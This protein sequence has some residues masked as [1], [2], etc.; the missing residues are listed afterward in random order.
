MSDGPERGSWRAPG[1]VPG[2]GALLGAAL[3]AGV[4]AAVAPLGDPDLPEHLAVGEWILRHGAVPWLEPF[5]WTRAG[6]P[7]YAYSWAAQVTYYGVLKLLGPV[8]LHLL[9]ALIGVGAVLAAALW[10]RRRG[11][12]AGTA[13]V[14]GALNFA[15]LGAVANQLRPEQLLFLLLPLAWALADAV[16]GDAAAAGGASQQATTAAPA[17]VAAWRRRGA[18]LLLGH[19]AVGCAAANV[20]LFFALTAAPLALRLLA[21]PSGRRHFLLPGLALVMGWLLS[22]Y[23][24]ALGDVLAL[25]F[26]P[27]VLLRRPPA[28]GEME[29]GFEA[30]FDVGAGA[31]LAILLLALPWVRARQAAP[32]RERALE[33]L[34]WAGGL[35]LF[36]YAYR[37]LAVW[38]LLS[39]PA[40]GAAVGAAAAGP[41]TR[42]RLR[43]AVVIGLAALMVGT[44]MP[45]WPRDLRLEGGVHRRTLPSS[46]AAAARPLAEWLVCHTGP[47]AGGRIFTSFNFGS[48]LTWRLPGYSV[49]LDGRTIFPDSVAREYAWALAGRNAPH[50]LT[51]AYADVAIIP[52][53]LAVNDALAADPSWLR[54]ADSNAGGGEIAILWARVAWWRR[55]QAPP[56][57]PRSRGSA[58]CTRIE[59]ITRE[60][61][62]AGGIP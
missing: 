6:Q 29:P 38:W 44:G 45:P 40:V 60:R 39:L 33:A 62:E 47:G 32:G 35:A 43:L 8:G 24:S 26:T 56:R 53:W 20:H 17:A 50:A 48:Y 2:R 42:P 46:P 19:L 55:W 49:S 36:A 22:P 23:G 13:A 52:R 41:G 16:A 61:A 5:A 12:G 51:W 37:L 34:V 15:A 18:L 27:N 28:I 7:Y 54:L 9:Q 30:M 59:G 31:V 57:A 4:L 1:G 21:A 10:A 11:W 3:A 14:V 25:N 58:S